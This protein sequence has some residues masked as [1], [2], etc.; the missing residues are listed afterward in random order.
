M[1]RA[2]KTKTTPKGVRLNWTSVK[3]VKTVTVEKLN[4]KGSKVFSEVTSGQRSTCNFNSKNFLI[5]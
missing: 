3:E 1:Q 4:I 5:P 2:M